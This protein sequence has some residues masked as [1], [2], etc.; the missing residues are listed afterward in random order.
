MFSN[1]RYKSCHDATSAPG[2]LTVQIRCTL[3]GPLVLWSWLMT[4][5]EPPRGKTNVVSE[6]VRHKAACASTEAGYRL[7]IL[8][9]RRRGIVLSEALISF[10]VTAKLICVFV[11]AYADCWFSHEAAQI[12][13]WSGFNKSGRII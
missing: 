5:N 1:P 3:T 13:D 10:V 11:F 6:Q 8:D 4:T 2:V 7:E 9:L 12:K